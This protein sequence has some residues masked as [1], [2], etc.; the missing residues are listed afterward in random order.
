MVTNQDFLS[1]SNHNQELDLSIKTNLSEDNSTHPDKSIKKIPKI[2]GNTLRSRL[3]MTVLPSVLVPLGFASFIGFK[4]TQ[5][6]AQD[7]ILSQLE[8]NVNRSQ[9]EAESFIKENF[10]LTDLVAVN[11]LII[12]ELKSINNNSETQRLSLVPIETLENSFKETK[13]LE[14][15]P[16]I[17]TY[18]QKL[19]KTG[20]IAEVFITNKDGFNIAY[21]NPTSDFVQRDEKWWQTA[22][23]EGISI[24]DPEYDESAKAVVVALA[25][26][27][28]DPDTGEVLG[29]IKT[30]VLANKLD[31]G[32]TDNI[33]LNLTET[34]TIQI[35][36]PQAGIP[37]NTVTKQGSDPENQTIVGGDNVLNFIK[38]IETLNNSES[39]INPEQIKSLEKQ[40]SLSDLAIK[41][42]ENE[43]NKEKTL[44]AQFKQQGKIFNLSTIPGSDW[45]TVASVDELEINRAG[46]ELLIVF[47]V[48]AIILGSLSI[49]LIVLLARN[50]SNPLT[51]LTHKAQ[52][53]ASGDL[54]VQAELA[55]TFE[56]KTLA[57]NFN[58]LILKVKTLLNQQ[59]LATEEQR[60]QRENIEN[61]IMI[62]VDEI[63]GAADGDL[64]VRASLDSLE[65]STVADLFNLIIENLKDI[66]T[67]VKQSTNKVSNSLETNEQSIRKLAEQSIQDV[68]EIQKT[69]SSIEQMSQSIE[70]VTN[71][72]THAAQSSE[73]AYQEVQKGSNAMDTT[74]TSILTLKNTVND[75][76]QK[77]KHLGESSQRISQVVAIIEEIA[78]KTNLLAIN[79]SVEA[80]RAGEQG[81]GFTVVAEQV[82]ALAEQS[83]NATK[84]ISQIIAAIQ[85]E[86]QEV[87]TQME[88]GTTQVVDASR[89]VETTQTYLTTASQKSQEINQLM[90]SI[91]QATVSQSETSQMVTSLM[92]KVSQS[93]QEKAS[94][95]TQIAEAIHQTKEVAKDLE[96]K[97]DQ[98]R[99]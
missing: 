37:L 57:N 18:I 36:S 27:I 39:T 93:S 26:A 29:V 65:L 79:A 83:S 84:E 15:N 73:E 42:S 21:S 51:K 58:D 44:F 5:H 33:S 45:V 47:G 50:L 77:M 4:I 92:K 75:T 66:A 89:L 96:S 46:Q 25:E 78:L 22:A 80:R 62:L 24:D 34:E 23:K 40:Y 94:S 91:S 2:L 9:N 48:T 90:Q 70:E 41:T 30:G 95:S 35:I 49:G 63:E 8:Q 53:V 56:V 74:V 85:R 71:N 67:E 69:L 32:L 60:E 72:A 14:S 16:D 38:E 6:K 81:Q 3:L 17:N 1:P 13:S 82:G 43:Q 28:K 64:T 19:V 97:V 76:A 10:A 98:F 55:G 61:A 52:Q 68:E 7:Q 54:N 99:V 20:R 86:T 88:T 12:D 31:E 87:A 11:P 59:E